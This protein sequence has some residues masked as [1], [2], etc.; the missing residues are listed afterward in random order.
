MQR[1]SHGNGT[2]C[3]KG[4]LKRGEKE[5]GGFLLVDIA[6]RWNK[7]RYTSGITMFDCGMRLTWDGTPVRQILV[8]DTSKAE[9][10]CIEA[11]LVTACSNLVSVSRAVKISL[12]STKCS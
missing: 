1:Q 4:A 11:N 8:V 2:I 3:V 10:I 6:G 7:L 9:A 5:A 12:F